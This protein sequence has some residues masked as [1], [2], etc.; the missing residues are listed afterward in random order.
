MISSS[1]SLSFKLLSLIGLIGLIWVM[2]YWGT[3][4]LL[5]WGLG[6]TIMSKS[7]M[8]GIMDFI[9]YLIVPIIILG[10]RLWKKFDEPTYL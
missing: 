1:Y 2:P 9:I 7:G 4:Y 3:G 6:I 8:V 5:G 10:I